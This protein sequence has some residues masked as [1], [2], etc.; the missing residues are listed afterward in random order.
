VSF[1]IGADG[2]VKRVFPQVT[3]KGHAAELL[4]ALNG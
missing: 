3:P 1:V 2:V 4:G